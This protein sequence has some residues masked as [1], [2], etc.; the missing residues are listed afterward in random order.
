ME[1]LLV[2]IIAGIVVGAYTLMQRANPPPQAALSSTSPVIQVTQGQ[3]VTVPVNAVIVLTPPPGYV[4]YN[5]AIPTS[6]NSEVIG[7]GPIPGELIAYS[8]GKAQVGG[9]LVPATNPSAVP[10]SILS[11]IIVQ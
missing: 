8:P 9:L 5:N 1:G 2:A 4:W 7:Y 6:S 11:T 3:N 10:T